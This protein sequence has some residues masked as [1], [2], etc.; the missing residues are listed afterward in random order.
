MVKK[1]RP[2]RPE[3]ALPPGTAPLPKS[4]DFL[5]DPPSKFNPYAVKEIPE[6][7]SNP[8][9]V[10]PIV[11]G[12]SNPYEVAPIAKGPPREKPKVSRWAFDLKAAIFF[13]CV[14][15]FSCCIC[16]YSVD[17]MKT[18]LP[19][20]FYRLIQTTSRE[21]YYSLHPLSTPPFML[22]KMMD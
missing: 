4:S 20:D 3:K 15:S 21:I 8:Y 22:L 2:E 13:G 5:Q 19:I 9:E 11:K 12:S 16:S 10:A 14:L 17:W 18:Y 7:P 1:T 6:K